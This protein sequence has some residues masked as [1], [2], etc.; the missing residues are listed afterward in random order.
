MHCFVSCAA[1]RLNHHLKRLSPRFTKEY[2]LA[3]AL[4]TLLLDFSIFS[5]PSKD[6]IISYCTVPWKQPSSIASGTFRGNLAQK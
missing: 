1:L 6:G 4:A 3:S 5:L 2:A